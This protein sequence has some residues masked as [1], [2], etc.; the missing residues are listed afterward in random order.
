MASMAVNA[1]EKPSSAYPKTAALL[2][3]VGGMI[4]ILGG[5]IFIG[6]ASFVIPHMNLSNLTV[7]QGMDK[8]SLPGLISGVLA[9]MGGFGLVCGAVVLVSATMLLAKVGTRRT[10]GILILVFSVLSFIG[11]GGFVLGAILGITGGVLTLRW[12][13]PTS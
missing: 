9:V 4:I 6:V 11:L 1:T 2:A 7:P 3:L 5:A 10:W 13:Q 12:K 8:A